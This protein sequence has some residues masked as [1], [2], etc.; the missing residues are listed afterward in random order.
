MNNYSDQLHAVCLGSPLSLE[1]LQFWLI[2]EAYHTRIIQVI[3]HTLKSRP[4]KNTNDF[5][6]SPIY[7]IGMKSLWIFK[8]VFELN[9]TQIGWFVKVHSSVRSNVIWANKVFYSI[10]S[11]NGK[12]VSN[13]LFFPLLS[14]IACKWLERKLWSYWIKSN[15]NF[16]GN[17]M[18]ELAEAI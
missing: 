1:C 11:E 6:P 3:N 8:N 9:E 5:S 18:L 10:E 13:L 17:K 14:E 15:P 16:P 12:N 7:Q 2:D 4:I